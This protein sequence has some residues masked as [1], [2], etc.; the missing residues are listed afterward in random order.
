MK[1]ARSL[2][3]FSYGLFT[4]AAQALLFREFITTFEGNDISVG[5]FFAS[6]F[7]WVG[8]GAI[9]VYRAQIIA[10]KLLKNIELLFLSYLPAFIL[11]LILIIQAR[12]LVGIES[13]ALWS[14]SAILIVSIIVNAPVS[15]ITGML[16]PTACRWVEKDQKL[17]V[18]QVYIIEAAGSFLGGLGVTVLLALG[19]SPARIFFILALF[20]SLSA[21][22]AQFTKARQHSIPTLEKT[23]KV[24]AQLMFLV[25]LCIL[26]CFFIR[27]DKT[28]MR[29][30]RVVKWTKLLPADSLTG[31]FRTAQAEYLYG[32]YQSQWVVMSQGSVIETLPDDSTAG[33]IAAIGLCQKPDSTKVLIIGSG[34][35]LCQQ[36]L[37][38]PQIQ[39]VSW[40]HC[41]NEYVQKIDKVIPSEFKIIDDRLHGLPGDIRS[42]LAKEKKAFDIVILNLPDATS[43]A[44]NRYYTLEFYRQVKEA[45][46]PN[47]I[48]Q[49]RVVGGENIMGTELINLGASTKLT[50]EKVFSQLVITPGEDTW[51]IASATAGREQGPTGDPA[52][53]RDRFAKIENATR[54]FNPQALL[55]VY[56]PDRAAAAVKYYAGA[57]LPEELLINR[58]SRPLTHLYSLLLAAKQSGAPVTKLIKHLA[59]AGP[60]AFVVP[61]LLFIV[62]RVIYILRTAQQGNKSGF[63]SSFLV[64]S[65]GWVSIG[66]VIV[67]M[68]LYQTRFGSLYL[69]IG[70][71]S[72][73]FMVGL[74]IGAAVTRNLLANNRKVQPEILLFVVI[75]VHSL[76]LCTIAFWPAKQL[77]HLTFVIAFVLC[78]LCAG[79]YFPIAAR[80]LADSAFE[81]GR[82]GSKLE[83][84]DHIGASVGGLL[85]SLALVPVLGARITLFGFILLILV[86]VPPALLRIYKAERVCSFDTIAFRLR[87]LGYILF[88]VGVSIVLCSNL[89]AE[90]GARLRPSLPQQSAQ[91]LAGE[92]HLEQESTVLSDSARKINYFRVSDANDKLTGYIFSSEDL[93]PKVRGFGGRINLAIYVDDPGGKLINFH[94]IRSNETPAYLELLGKWRSSLNER[95]LF[96]PEPFADVHAVTGATVSSEAILSALQT[97]GRRFATQILGRVV[98]AGPKEKT[99]R[100]AYLPDNHGIYLIGAFVLALIVIYR[101]GFWSRLVVLLFNLVL[102][103]IIL[104]TQYS[105]EQIATLL[106]VHTP[107]FRLTGAFLLVIGVP[108]LVIIFG[109][110]YCGYICPFGAAQELL[111]YVLPGRFKQPIQAE[112]MRKARFV[113]YVVLLVLIIVFFLSRNRTTLAADPLISIFNPATLGFDRYPLLAG[114][115]SIYD[116]QSAMLLTVVTVLIGSIF[117]GRFWCRYL[118]PAGAF[119]SLLN[120]VAI[121]KRYLP[122]K[123]FG[124]CEFGLNTKDKMDC[125]HCDRCRYSKQGSAFRTKTK[126]S[127]VVL[128]I[129]PKMAQ[130]KG[131]LGTGLVPYVL[132]VAI[133]VSAVSISRFMQVVP[134]GSD[135]YIALAPSGGQ[136]RDVDMQRIRTLVEQK[137]LSDREA[138]FYKKVE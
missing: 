118:C 111:G 5:I 33:R 75:F 98:E 38:L 88:G 60:L 18:S 20:V 54:L 41:D 130:G 40:A 89:L 14:V 105:S 120:N 32:V 2:L 115:F 103:G 43:S 35:G 39:T 34:L 59:L 52:I 121:L 21:A 82:A 132:A 71:V 85:T 117:Y 122:A 25:P 133:F 29:Y 48:F 108:L 31:S 67:L 12:E 36:F 84:A 61:V 72:S 57:D 126:P 77:T 128:P 101:G 50:L 58:D 51:F 91:A 138:E 134:M 93:A 19:I 65:A 13:Y 8:L 53:L 64:F 116:F 63:D 104:N 131:L 3:I 97:S 76:I 125:I 7:L 28:L 4:I 81:T 74:T 123:K 17:P 79:F 62:L 95:Q 114:R 80:Q 26:L 16:F 30:I 129:E 73:M 137:R 9:V 119:L 94:I 6:W 10:E 83:T 49:V 15:I 136:S 46:K 27:A 106:S 113:K 55:S 87:K 47:G 56:L 86:N 11:Q 44:L 110:I 1:L 100:A 78:G 124:R 22:L 135:Y 24:K 92:L 112:A 102:G 127:K 45:L 68:Y 90:A 69:Y 23:A 107:A 109:N 99:H 42:L 96:Q 37:Y 66:V 70:V